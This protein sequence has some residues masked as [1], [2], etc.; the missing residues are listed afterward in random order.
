MVVLFAVNQLK[1]LSIRSKFSKLSIPKYNLVEIYGTSFKRN[2]L[3]ANTQC[4]YRIGAVGFEPETW[5]S[6]NTAQHF[7]ITRFYL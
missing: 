6:K 4:Y 3:L 7:G 2:L 5:L 1:K